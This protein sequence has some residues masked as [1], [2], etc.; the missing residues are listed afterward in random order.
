MSKIVRFYFLNPTG[1]ESKTNLFV[2]GT[3]KI[4]NGE[5]F[6]R[7]QNQILKHLPVCDVVSGFGG[8]SKKVVGGDMG[9]DGAWKNPWKRVIKLEVAKKCFTVKH[10]YFSCP[11][12]QTP[13]PFD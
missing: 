8:E 6:L 13:L 12:P 1:P 9:V 3:R 11:S 7:F 2:K 5:K 4:E 10:K